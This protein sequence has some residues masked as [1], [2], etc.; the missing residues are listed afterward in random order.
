MGFYSSSS[1]T[2]SSL[3]KCFASAFNTVPRMRASS[4]AKHAYMN[5]S[6]LLLSGVSLSIIPIEIRGYLYKYSSGIS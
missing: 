6:R 1:N 3:G 2:S 4:F 5:A